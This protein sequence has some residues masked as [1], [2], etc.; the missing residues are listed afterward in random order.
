MGLP[1]VGIPNYVAVEGLALALFFGAVYFKWVKLIR[2]I[3]DIIAFGC[4]L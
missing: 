2:K 1:T 3:I 4:S